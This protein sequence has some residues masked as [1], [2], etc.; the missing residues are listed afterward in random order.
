MLEGLSVRPPLLLCEEFLILKY[1][2][3]VHGSSVV[4]APRLTPQL[5]NLSTYSRVLLWFA[6]VARGAGPLW[7]A[8]V[9]SSKGPGLG[10]FQ[11]LVAGLNWY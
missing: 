10:G 2:H 1:A 6:T 4:G 11:L 9:L 8:R 7:G 3:A 5:S